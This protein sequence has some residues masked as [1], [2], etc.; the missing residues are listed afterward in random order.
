MSTLP[1]EVEA[2]P[3][4]NGH[5]MNPVAAWQRIDAMDVL[6]GFA[7]I[8]I[9]M[10]NIEWFNRP[11]ASLGSF[12]WN[13][14]GLD[15]SAGWFV[16]VFVEGK[17]YKLFSLL[18]GMGFAVMLLRA[19]ENERPFG[20]MM[21][22]RMLALL[23]FGLVH[24][25][26]LWNGDILHDYAIGGLALMGWLWLLRRPKLQRF[27]NP[28]SI[29]RFALFMLA[30]PFIVMTVVG[31]GYGLAVD[32][33]KLKTKHEE[34]QLA[35]Q[36]YIAKVDEFKAKSEDE[37]LAII[38]AHEE[39]I[40]AEKKAEEEAAK[41]GEK[42]EKP[43]PEKMSKDERIKKLVDDR[44]A[45]RLE[46]E[47]DEITE[48]SVLTKGSYWDTVV[49]RFKVEAPH[50]AFTPIFVMMMLL[51][52]FLL[53]YWLIVTGKMLNPKEHIRFFRGMMY[54]GLGF[55]VP[56]NLVA[57]MLFVHP[58]ARDVD[59]LQGISGGLFNLGQYVLCAGYVGW[60]V[61]LVNSE[62]WHK[63]VLWLAP[64]GRM[65][66]T[67]YLTHS[68]VLST[69]FYGYGFG[70]F[71]HIARG[72]QM[73]VVAA[74]IAVQWVFSRWW[75]NNFHYGPLEWVWRCITYWKMQPLRI[76]RAVTTKAIE[77]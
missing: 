6:R 51:W 46:N 56:L 61:V 20:A 3:L 23:G 27:N 76:D 39:K 34:A 25:F 35:H 75:L 42:K 47:K 33:A 19:E 48:L 37:K 69:L 17:L 11:I 62:R 67:N 77:A 22:R 36:Q 1:N 30:L 15:Y 12:D 4:T 18:F 13:M 49:H 54:I 38:K 26:L 24:M 41:N 72:P 58:G 73:L 32:Q 70:Q 14:V 74:V 44:F 57:F 50:L 59:M 9:L 65:A 5:E 31:I 52:I 71:G 63:L 2:G 8:G 10:M 45:R 43:D 68:L 64:L 40:E 29:R 28:T 55:G 21:V 66:L 60:F 7:L 16:K 53:G